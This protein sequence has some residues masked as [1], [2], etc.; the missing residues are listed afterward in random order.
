MKSTPLALLSLILIALLLTACD[1]NPT[2]V[3]EVADSLEPTQPASSTPSPTLTPSTT[4]TPSPTWTAM[5]TLTPTSTDTPS[6]TPTPEHPLMIEVMR[7][8]SYPGSELVIEEQIDPGENYDRYI[9]SYQSEGNTIYAL[10]T[11]LGHTT[12]N[13]LAGDYLQPWLY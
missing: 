12:G 1:Q 2:A 13:R 9:A 5:P 10:L 4:P 8:Q 3:A 11:I 7:R 6:P